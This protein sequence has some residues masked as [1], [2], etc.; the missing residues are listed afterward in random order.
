M[1][2]EVVPP[3]EAEKIL[4]S[5]AADLLTDRLLGIDKVTNVTLIEGQYAKA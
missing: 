5:I 4:V 1:Q 3:A 2:Y